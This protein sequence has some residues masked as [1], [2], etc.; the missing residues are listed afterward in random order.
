MV[1]PTDRFKLMT[2]GEKLNLSLNLYHTARE[3]KRSWLKLLHPEWD[4]TAV[5]S[6]VRRVFMK[7]RSKQ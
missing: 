1:P 4:E 2:A 6:E 7:A 3:L 5:E